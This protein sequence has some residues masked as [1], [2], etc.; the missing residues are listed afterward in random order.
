M[1]VLGSERNGAKGNAVAKRPERRYLALSTAAPATRLLHAPGEYQMRISLVG[2]ISL[3]DT[4]YSSSLIDNVVNRTTIV[5][6]DLNYK[7]AYAGKK[8]M[9]RPKARK[10]KDQRTSR[11]TVNSEDVRT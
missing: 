6:R 5:F 8:G 7:S 10:S 4:S 2:S 11:C 9:A 1:P 3:A